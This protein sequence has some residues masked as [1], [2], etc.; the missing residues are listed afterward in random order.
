VADEAAARSA[1]MQRAWTISVDSKL[2]QARLDSARKLGV[3]RNPHVDTFNIEALVWEVTQFRMCPSFANVYRMA[4]H[5]DGQ[6][7]MIELVSLVRDPQPLLDFAQQ[8]LPLLLSTMRAVIEASKRDRGGDT[9]L[10]E[11]R[12]LNMSVSVC[13]QRLLLLR[14]CCVAVT[15]P[16]GQSRDEHAGDVVLNCALHSQ[17][18]S[19]CVHDVA[20]EICVSACRR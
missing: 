18:A 4:M 13:A 1:A 14:R 11:M 7:T 2:L 16:R 15:H 17:G 3:K 6:L 8:H 10:N 19:G 9:A 20:G 5:G 12:V